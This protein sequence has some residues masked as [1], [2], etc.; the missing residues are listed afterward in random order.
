V[1]FWF[2]VIPLVALVAVVVGFTGW[3]RLAFWPFALRRGQMTVSRLGLAVKAPVDVDRVNTLLQSFAGGFNAMI[4]QPSASAWQCYCD[5]LPVLYRPFA[6]EGAAMGYT[7]RHL[8]RYRAGDFEEGLVK[9]HPEFRYLYY[10]GLGFWSGMRNHA[11]RKVLRIA[12]GL[13]PL[14]GY[15]CYDGYGF[16]HAFFDYPKDPDALRR[17]EVLGGY[18]TNAAYQGVGRAF[19][20]LYMSRPE[21][22]VEHIG[23]LGGHAVDA[24]AGVGLAAIFVNPDRLEVA[25]RLATELPAEWHD[26]FHLGMCFG[27]KARS[28]N[29]MEQFERDMDGVDTPVREA[30]QASVREC[31]RVELLVRSEDSPD[32]YRIWRERVARWMA[33]HIEYP[34]AGVKASPRGVDRAAT[35]S[36]QLPVAGH[37]HSTIGNR[38]SNNGGVVQ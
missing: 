18:A 29:D 33:E 15:L 26:H 8:F 37:R 17:L 6:H 3:W 38:R 11:A 25:R 27:L 10:V 34:L 20:F 19:F 9:I 5:S 22:L 35:V 28:I 2:L 23:R 14:H 12:D 32:G 4:A 21:L 30:I 16:K 24:A 31:D 13:D 36:S 1:H 7:L